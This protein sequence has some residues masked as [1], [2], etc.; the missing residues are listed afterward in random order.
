MI[1]V[2]MADQDKLGFDLISAG[3]GSRVTTKK[4]IHQDIII[5]NFQA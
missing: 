1:A 2:A 4:R 3:A 5:A